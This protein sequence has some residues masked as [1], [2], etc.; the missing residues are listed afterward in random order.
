[1]LVDLLERDGPPG[2]YHAVGPETTTWH[3]F[4]VRAIRAATGETPEIAP[5]TTDGFPTP[6]VRPK[7]SALA[8]TRLGP[9]GIEPMR[10]LDEALRDWAKRAVFD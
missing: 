4:A 8:D 3:N 7:N 10:P 2:V 6:A 5:V 9:L 1:V